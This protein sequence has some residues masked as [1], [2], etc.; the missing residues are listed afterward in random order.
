M[1]RRKIHVGP[2][3]LVPHGE[4]P[5]VRDDGRPESGGRDFG[6]SG[7]DVLLLLRWLQGQLRPDSREVREVTS[8]RQIFIRRGPYQPPW[9]PASGRGSRGARPCSVCSS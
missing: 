6:L 5:S 3:K 9:L 2:T 1:G 8:L 7:Q 4:G